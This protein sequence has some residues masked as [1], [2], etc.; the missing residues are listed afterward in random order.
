MRIYM[1][2]HPKATANDIEFGIGMLIKVYNVE[3]KVKNIS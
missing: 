1:Y 3:D 2:N